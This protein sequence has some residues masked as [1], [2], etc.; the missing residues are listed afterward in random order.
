VLECADVSELVLN[1]FVREGQN[2]NEKR[3]ETAQFAIQQTGDPKS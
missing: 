1:E 3:E 2:A